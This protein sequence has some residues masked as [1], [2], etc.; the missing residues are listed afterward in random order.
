MT[1]GSLLGNSSV[2]TTDLRLSLLF[3]AYLT[4]R[5]LTAHTAAG[6]PEKC[7]ASCFLIN[8]S[9][10]RVWTCESEISVRIES[11]I[12]PAATIRIR[13]ESRIESGGSRLHVQCRLSCG[14]CVY[15]NVYAGLLPYTA[16]YVVCSVFLCLYCRSTCL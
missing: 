4:R 6:L 8:Y 3:H 1:V 15:N 9:T 7:T 2:L 11:E 14:S 5:S 10:L 16:C 12:E 13:I